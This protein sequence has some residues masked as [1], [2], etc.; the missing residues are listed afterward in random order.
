LMMITDRVPNLRIVIGHLGGLT[1]PT[2]SAPRQSVE[3][4]LR[5]LGK[6]PHVFA[7]VTMVA[8]MTNEKADLDPNTYTPRLDLLWDLFGEDRLI[9]GSDWPNSAGNWISFNDV[10]KIV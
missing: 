4:N 7:K 6:R 5:E 3:S 1:L 2:D 8:R 10:L 9:F